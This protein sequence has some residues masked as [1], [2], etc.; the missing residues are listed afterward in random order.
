MMRRSVSEC[1]CDV[2]YAG[3]VLTFNSFF[4]TQEGNFSLEIRSIC[5]LVEVP[6]HA[7][8]QKARQDT[9]ALEKGRGQAEIANQGRVAGIVSNL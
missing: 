8:L 6:K 3:R 1:L 4:G 5:A 2:R 7:S 9:G